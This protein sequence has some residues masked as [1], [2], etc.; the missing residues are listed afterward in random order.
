M[1][2]CQ[3]VR[4]IFTLG[5]G[6]LGDW[7]GLDAAI[8]YADK[9]VE[10]CENELR[11]CEEDIR[12]ARDNLAYIQSELV[13]FD[14]LQSNIKGYEGQL[15]STNR[16]FIE[17][18]NKCRELTNLSFDIS[19]FLGGL[20]ARSETMRT[21]LTA[22]QFAKAVL[23]LQELMVTPTKVKGLLANNPTEYESTL[24]MISRGDEM[25]DTLEDLM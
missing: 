6:R 3:L 16:Q 15:Q 20:A 12:T 21:K 5:L 19:I 2:D 10:S 4:D 14:Q 1:R 13:R 17:L 25:D 18:N 23:S 11:V 8:K 22:A 9:L 24:E 7:G